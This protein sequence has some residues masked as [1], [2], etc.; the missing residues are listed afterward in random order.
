MK[1]LQ[2]F[3]RFGIIVISH[4]TEYHINPFVPNAPFLYSLKTSENRKVEKGSRE[5]VEKGCIGSRE[6]AKKECIESEWVNGNI[7]IQVCLLNETFFDSFSKKRTSIFKLS[8]FKFQS[9]FHILDNI[10]WH[11]LDKSVSD[12]IFSCT[13][14]RFWL[15]NRRNS[16]KQNLISK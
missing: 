2:I 15:N 10:L 6:M 9:I 8:F 5:S 14:T 3:T 1:W 16:R 12:F 11:F 13:L 4:L 7:S